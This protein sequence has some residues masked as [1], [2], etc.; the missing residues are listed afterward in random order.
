MVRGPC[1]HSLTM[2]WYGGV[3]NRCTQAREHI[4][5]SREGWPQTDWSSKDP[6]PD[7]LVSSYG[8]AI[9]HRV[10]SL[11]LCSEW[12]KLFL[13][14]STLPRFQ[15]SCEFKSFLWWGEVWSNVE[16]RSMTWWPL[17]ERTFL[18]MNRMWEGAESPFWHSSTD[19]FE[20]SKKPFPKAS[21]L[22][23]ELF[24]FLF[25]HERA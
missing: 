3:Q 21:K 20:A 4:Y 19:L 13:F 16:G 8:R 24:S 11:A 6:L 5:N 1:L 25:W 15:L 12:K 23:L 9:P 2:F 17:G 18:R 7:L 14:K 10:T 22:V